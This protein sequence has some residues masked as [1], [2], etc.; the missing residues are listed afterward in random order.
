[1]TFAALDANKNATLAANMTRRRGSPAGQRYGTSSRS[2]SLCT[3]QKDSLGGIFFSSPVAF[4]VL[5]PSSTRT[6]VDVD[7]DVCATP[8]PARM[9][10]ARALV[11][12]AADDRVSE[13]RGR[14][15]GRGR[16]RRGRR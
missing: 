15:R 5:A 16:G 3:L 12:A 8:P 1:M 7:V 14:G 4:S 2:S 11:A 13:T 10:P 9:I 6:V